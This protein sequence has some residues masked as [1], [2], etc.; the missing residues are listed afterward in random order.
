MPPDSATRPASVGSS[1][2]AM[3][4]AAG[5]APSLL[6]ASY[7]SLVL[8]PLVLAWL[9]GAQPRRFGDNLAAAAGMVGLVMLL[10]EFILSGR[11]RLISGRIGIDV[12][13]RFHRVMAI[14]LVVF[15]LVHP[16]LYVTP[17]VRA[18]DVPHAPALG[19]DGA[20][21]LTGALAWLLTC[22]LLLTAFMRDRSG[23]TYESWRQTHAALATAIACL[24]VHHA[25]AAG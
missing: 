12:T 6:V 13:M 3:S 20:S 9:A 21:L 11:F 5:L 7:A 14:A 15:V 10:L 8:T 18:H 24:G 4:R 19:L 22:G 17:M 2:Q 1:R 25:V 23:M 16:F